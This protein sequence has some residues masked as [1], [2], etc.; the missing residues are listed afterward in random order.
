MFMNTENSKRNKPH[1]FVLNLSQRLDLRSL[2][3]HVKLQSLY[4]YY[5]WK[6]IRKHYKNNKQ[7]IIASTWNDEFQLQ[8]GFCSVSDIPDYIEYIIKEHGTL[9]TIFQFMFT[10]TELIT[11]WCLKYQMDMG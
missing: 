3:K 7:K 1:K 4:V 2:N 6:N 9:T 5:T 8:D 11:Y 10:P